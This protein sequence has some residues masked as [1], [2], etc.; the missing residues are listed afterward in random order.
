MD[1]IIADKIVDK[2]FTV[3]DVNLSG[4]QLGGKGWT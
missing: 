1:G 4:I 3:I 2:F